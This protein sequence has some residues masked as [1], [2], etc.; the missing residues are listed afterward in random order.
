MKHYFT[1]LLLFMVALLNAQ[2]IGIQEDFESL[3]NSQ[4]DLPGWTQDG[5]ST[6]LSLYSCFGTSIDAQ[7][8]GSSESTAQLVSPNLIKASNG[9]DITVDFM[10]KI[11]F[12]G[13]FGASAPA[14]SGWGSFTVEY[15]IN[16]TD[17]I[18][19]E[20]F[21]NTNYDSVD[22]CTSHSFTIA[23][24]DVP[25]D[26]DF[27]IRWSVIHLDGDYSVFF[28][29]V[30]VTQVG[31]SVPDCSATVIIPENGAT[32]IDPASGVNVTW[33]NA[34]GVFTGYKLSVGTTEG[35]TDLIDKL[36][37]GRTNSYNVVADFAFE[38]EYFI[39][40]TPYNDNGDATSACASSSFTTR[41]AP[42]QGTNC[43]DPIIIDPAA[44]NYTVSGTSEGYEDTYSSMPCG[45]NY[46][47]SGN[48]VVYAITPTEKMSIN[49]DL[50]NVT[51]TQ[52]VVSIMDDCPDTATTCLGTGT[53]G[54]GLEDVSIQ[55]IVL[56]ADTQYFVI[57]STTSTTKFSTYDLAIS[58]NS[59]II[60]SATYT[61][62]SDCENRA[63]SVDVDITDLGS[64]TS[65]VITDGETSQ[66]VT[67]LGIAT[68]GPYA[69]GT[70]IDFSVT[71]VDDNACE[72]F[73][74]VDFYCA[75]LNDLCADATEV[76]INTD[77]SCDLKT[78]GTTI[79]STV[80][81]G[82]ESVCTGTNYGDV[83]FKF[84]ATSENLDFKIEDKV[85]YEGTSVNIGTEFY[86]GSCGEFTSI[87]C[88]TTDYNPLSGLTVGEVYYVRV[89][90]RSSG[91]SHTFNVCINTPADA[92]VNDECTGAIALSVSD[93]TCDNKI[94]G[95]TIGAT[96]SDFESCS[97]DRRDVWYSF[98]PTEDAYYTITLSEYTTAYY[99][100]LEGDCETGEFTDVLGGCNGRDDALSFSADKQY[101]IFVRS[102][103]IDI[104]ETF[105][106]CVTPF[107]P[108]ANNE[109]TDAIA[110]TESSDLN[111]DNK[112]IG[113]TENALNST[114]VDCVNSTYGVV[115][116]SF[117]PS[118]SGLYHIDL[119]KIDGGNAYFTVFSGSCAEGFT[120]LDE[121][122]SCYNRGT[123]DVL[124]EAGIEYIIPVYASSASN[125]ELMAYPDQAL[126]ISET[127]EL[128][129][130]VTVFPNPVNNNLTIVSKVAVNTITVYNTLGQKVLVTEA[131]SSNRTE[132]SFSALQNG[133]Y[134]V[135]VDS[136]N[137]SQTI[138]VVKQ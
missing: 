86:T 11:Y 63:F 32:D 79:S 21:D 64:A 99:G 43:S 48:E 61:V 50:T 54:S 33:G 53:S 71:N 91:T 137:A 83:W 126:S 136:D 57:V 114:A 80:T 84:T 26:S 81:D 103:L 74:T 10:S 77:D 118:Q 93:A 68:F 119:T 16:G 94:S 138:R 88:N 73:E 24:A 18:E 14:P 3:S 111:G 67:A 27:Q 102:G 107:T 121:L 28:D 56:E 41:S 25:E 13:F 12:Y 36:N 109:C 75:P 39:T 70:S 112:I 90:T 131:S 44:L 108:V 59:C 23:G 4:S 116:Y 17:W 120:A 62:N 37:L 34:T 9:T 46:L 22:A 110:L 87:E 2:Q 133:F 58:E 117:M 125:F 51:E 96:E 5:F 66:T 6:S 124:L 134:F 130:G 89:Y 7:F 40:I 72:I 100:V 29:N 135:K 47:I 97:T 123:K 95:S 69:S 30:S 128:A 129:L 106:L 65:L 98:T 85:N 113:T 105:D 20:T 101:Y 42:L 82:F 127:S 55:D 31:T 60:P 92:P 49:I 15:S 115:W 78:W 19:I 104:G 45:A 132:V 76:A 52:T 8:S 122:T 35:G 38:T 1:L